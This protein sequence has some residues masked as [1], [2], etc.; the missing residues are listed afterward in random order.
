VPC[1]ELS[2][3]RF[4]RNLYE[5]TAEALVGSS[6]D[7]SRAIGFSHPRPLWR[8]AERLGLIVLGTCTPQEIRRF[9]HFHDTL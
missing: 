3:T 5:A 1:N 2:L 9:E 4:G 7:A 6:I 8:T